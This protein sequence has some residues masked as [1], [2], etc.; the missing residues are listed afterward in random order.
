MDSIFLDLKV[1][2]RWEV[3]LLVSKRIKKEQYLQEHQIKVNY[4]FVIGL[5]EVLIKQE[6]A[7]TIQ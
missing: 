2:E 1:E 7:K 3:H 4:L 5:Q 6:E